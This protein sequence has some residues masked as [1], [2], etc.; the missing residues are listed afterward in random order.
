MR[1]AF[2]S[3]AFLGGRKF[4]EPWEMVSAAAAR[5]G[6]DLV[7]FTNAKLAGPVG[8]ATFLE[9]RLGG[10]DFVVFWDKDV[11]L[12]ANLEL[13]GYPVFNSSEC[14][15]VCD[16]K[17]LTHLA[18]AERGVRSIETVACPMSFGEY[19]DLR[20]AEEAAEE[21]GYPVV[22]KDRAGSF[23]M[24]VGLARDPEELRSMLSPYRPCIL[25]RYVECS[26]VDVRVEVVGG[27]AV[28]AMT[29]RSAEG[30][31]RSNA[32]LG[33]TISA[34]EPD[35]EETELAVR[36]CEAV[37]AD[38]AGVDV[39]RSADGPVV[40]EVNSNAHLRNLADCT[41]VD[42]SDSIIEHIVRKVGG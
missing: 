21:L 19:G 4:S 24:Q 10:A 6:V 14:I 31:F 13:C 42:A 30:D 22:V 9:G 29:R 8:D 17:A 23:G 18:L 41:G 27:R 16:D 39:L 2:V 3:N 26:G 12:A 28:A 35:P 11:A 36:A 25:Q 5:A 7:R 20:F 38:F 37:G 32:T 40:C 15:R 33:G 34:H 1:G